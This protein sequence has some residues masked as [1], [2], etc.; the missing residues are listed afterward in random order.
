MTDRL[1]YKNSS[2]KDAYTSAWSMREV[3]KIHLWHFVWLIFFR[4]TP[5]HFF[6]GWRLF[7]LK[8]FGA[9]IY[10]RPFVFPTSKVFA[11]WL[12]QLGHKS[13]LGPYSEMYNLG[14]VFIGA[15]VTVSQYSYICNGT[16]DLCKDNLPLMVGDIRIGHN[17]FLG[18]KC[19]ILPGIHIGEYAV[20]GAGSVVTKDVPPYNIVGGNPAKFLKLRIVSKR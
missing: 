6:N 1:W 18:A 3:I 5:K 11:P 12:L 17:A 10:G 14:P 9:G 15:K 8:L 19:L 20:I 4:P 7:L 16:H 13:C 2:Q